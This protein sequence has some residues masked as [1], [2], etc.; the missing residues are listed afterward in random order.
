MDKLKELLEE[1]KKDNPEL[2]L[3][4]VTLKCKHI[5]ESFNKF[6][7][8]ISRLGTLK[9]SRKLNDAFKIM[10]DKLQNKLNKDEKL[11]ESIT[12]LFKQSINELN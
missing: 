2:S 9:Q 4:D 11:K 5:C 6:L 8:F 7:D 10:L 12:P 1:K 3:D